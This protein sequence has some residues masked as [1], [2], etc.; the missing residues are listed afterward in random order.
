MEPLLGF[1]PRIPR[2]EVG[3]LSHWA[4]GARWRMKGLNHT[5]R[6]KH[7]RAHYQMLIPR[8]LKKFCRRFPLFSVR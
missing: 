3:C 7:N 8:I 6:E 1:E 2:L 4:I 5:S